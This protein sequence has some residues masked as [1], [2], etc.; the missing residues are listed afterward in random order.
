MSADKHKKRDRAFAFIRDLRRGGRGYPRGEA[1]FAMS[2]PPTPVVRYCL[3][4]GLATIRRAAKWTGEVRNRR[5][6]FSAD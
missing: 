4:R 2:G 3:G 1:K 5:N 6:I